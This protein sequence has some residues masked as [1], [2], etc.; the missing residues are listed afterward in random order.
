MI[1]LHIKL[2]RIICGRYENNLANITFS[3]P[4]FYY[5][6]KVRIICIGYYV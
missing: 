4:K 2:K 3:T 6:D 5:K 1:E